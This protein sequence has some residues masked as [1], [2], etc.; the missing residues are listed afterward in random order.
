MEYSKQ[1]IASNGRTVEVITRNGNIYVNGVSV[2]TGKINAMYF[3]MFAC[4]VAG[5]VA[6]VF[7]CALSGV[8]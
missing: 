4:F 1:T 7:S 5:I 3:K 2:E 8:L 6:T